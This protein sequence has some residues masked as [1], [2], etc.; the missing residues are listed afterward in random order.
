MNPKVKFEVASVRHIMLPIN[1]FLNPEEGWDWSRHILDNYPELDKLLKNVKGRSQRGKIAEDFFEKFVR[2]NKNLLEKKASR[3]QQEWNKINNRYMVALSEVLE[4]RWKKT[5][6]EI[7][8]FVSPNPI[9]PRYIKKRIFDVYYL[10]SKEW[11]KSVAAHEILHFLYFEKWKK[12]F[13]KTPE[14]HFDAPHL[15]WQLSE[16]VPLSILSDKRLQKILPHKPKVYTEYQ[17]LKIKG[18]PLL[19]HIAEFYEQSEDFEDFLRKSWNFVKEN[20]KAIGGAK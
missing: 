14:R 13:P 11:M 3:F 9:C 4:I 12:I 8:A 18:K 16:M 1:D 19:D 5:D 17:A 10:S 20:K 7:R 2:A 15:E 6:K